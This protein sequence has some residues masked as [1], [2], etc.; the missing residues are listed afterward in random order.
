MKPR[1][2]S[3]EHKAQL[4]GELLALT[5]NIEELYEIH[6]LA[7]LRQSA[8]MLQVKAA[9][10]QEIFRDSDGLLGEGAAG[11]WV[12]ER[13]AVSLLEKSAQSDLDWDQLGAASSFAQSGVR[14]LAESFDD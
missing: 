6:D 5:A 14:Q 7:G 13:A 4:V 8:A 2:S 10:A 3:P 12:A 11:A 9:A 1:D